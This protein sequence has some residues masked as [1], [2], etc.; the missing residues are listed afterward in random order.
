M[1]VH[2]FMF[3]NIGRWRPVLLLAKQKTNL[4]LTSAAI[5]SSGAVRTLFA[6]TVKWKF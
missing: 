2:L 3:I 5:T 1:C 4:L 6:E